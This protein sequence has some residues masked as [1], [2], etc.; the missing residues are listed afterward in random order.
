MIILYQ[1]WVMNRIL[2]YGYALDMKTV[3]Q[4]AVSDL[5]RNKKRVCC[6]R[7]HTAAWSSE[8]IVM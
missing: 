8:Q 7:N 3:T 1:L 6:S 2:A 5:D 4:L